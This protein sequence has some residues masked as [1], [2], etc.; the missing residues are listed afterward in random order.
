MSLTI[1]QV[2][3]AK[4]PVGK[5]QLR[6]ADSAGLYL[7][8][9]PSGKYWRMNYRFADKQKTLALGVFPSISLKQARLDRDSAKKLLTKGIDPGQAK[10]IEKRRNTQAGLSSFKAISTEWLS[11]YSMKWAD[12]TIKHTQARLDKHI[13]PWIGSLPITKRWTPFAGQLCGIF[14]VDSHG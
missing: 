12:T 11:K 2:K 5:K 9:T 7:H 14:K 1:G 8:V 10:K 13:H 4:V 3:A 6:L